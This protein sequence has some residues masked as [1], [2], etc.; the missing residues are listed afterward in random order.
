MPVVFPSGIWDWTDVNDNTDDVLAEHMNDTAHEVE[1]LEAKVGVDSSAV[2][3]SHDYLLTHL[4]EQVTN[5]D[6]GNSTVIT[7]S[8]FIS[9]VTTGTA[10]FTVSSTTK[11]TNLNAATVDDF[12]FRSGD[13][14]FSSS[15]S[16]PTGWTD[17]SSTYNGKFVRISSGTALTTG[18]TDTHNHGGSSGAYT[19]QIADMP[20]HTHSVT[21]YQVS[22]AN[23]SNWGHTETVTNPNSLTTGSA[24]G[25]GSHSHSIT[26]ADNIPAYVQVKCY[27]K[28]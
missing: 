15:A 11:V 26:T 27:K 3:T 6:A 10:P 12:A 16:T 23:G 8:R 1:A 17:V 25:G 2:A 28:D 19:L 20:S 14:L 24:G 13:L 4:P 9:E 5:W 22:G 18:G 7:A 21:A